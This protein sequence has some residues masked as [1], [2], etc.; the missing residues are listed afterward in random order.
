MT[1]DTSSTV[2]WPWLRVRAG[3]GDR[4]SVEA[5]P[6]GEAL[7]GRLSRSGAS[8]NYTWAGQ[9]WATHPAVPDRLLRRLVKACTPTRST[10]RT[11][12]RAGKLAREVLLAATVDR[13]A[14]STALSVASPEQLEELRDRVMPPLLDHYAT[15]TATK[16][17]KY[18][19]MRRGKR[20]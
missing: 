20:G 8:Y 16:A 15:T 3:E 12:R 19:D 13:E 1:A 18:A 4:T 10:D 17:N 7:S 2:P 6:A 14:L 9:E 5:G 11:A